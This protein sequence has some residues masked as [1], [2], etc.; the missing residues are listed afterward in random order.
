MRRTPL[1][2]LR[3]GLS[4]L[5]TKG[6]VNG[7][8]LTRVV[9]RAFGLANT[10]V[11]SVALDSDTGDVVISA[12]PKAGAGGRCGRCQRRC[13]S[14]DQGSGRRRWRAADLGRLRCFVEAAA[15]RVR[16]PKHG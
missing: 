10:V 1:A 16:C 8:R 11:E 15:P 6:G 7:V 2:C 13:S 14:F 5:E 12:R 9:G 4:K 3:F